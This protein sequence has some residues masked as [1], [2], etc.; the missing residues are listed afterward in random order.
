MVEYALLLVLVM[1]AVAP[2]VR[3]L[4]TRV[5]SGFTAAVALFGP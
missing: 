4:G 3:S 1:V 5:A 2:A